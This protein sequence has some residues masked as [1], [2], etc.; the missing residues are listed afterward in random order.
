CP[1]ARPG[2]ATVAPVLE[3]PPFPAV[4]VS[5]PVV[6]GRP[7]PAPA[8]PDPPRLPER[9]DDRRDSQARH[10]PHAAP[11]VR[12]ASAR[13][14][15]QPAHHSDS[16]GT[17]VVQHHGDL[18]ASDRTSGGPTA[19]NAQPAHARF[20]SRDHAGSGGDSPPMRCGL[21]RPPCAVAQSGARP[22]GHPTVPHRLFRRSRGAVRP[23]RTPALCLSLLSQSALSQ[24]PRS[25]DPSL[26]RTT[27]PTHAARAPL[28][29][30][31]HAAVRTALSLPGASQAALRAAPQICRFVVA[32]TD[33]RSALPG[34]TTRH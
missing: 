28:S 9:P 29:T 27:R 31:L 25:T 14:R 3:D 2:V 6:L 5:V 19:A 30:D 7:A 16:A 18:H 4:A 15:R 8:G 26:A 20:V 23:L 1:A 10:R 33:A 21:P 24:V 22:A 13:S 12:H 11:L 32:Q 17:L 34:C